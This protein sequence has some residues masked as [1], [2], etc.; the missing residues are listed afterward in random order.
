MPCVSGSYF[1]FSEYFLIFRLEAYPLNLM[2]TTYTSDGYSLRILA[3]I[4]HGQSFNIYDLWGMYTDKP[5]AY[6]PK[7]FD[8]LL[9]EKLDTIG[10]APPGTFQLS[11]ALNKY[12]MDQLQ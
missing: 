3:I 11:C 2:V 7:I 5:P 9:W 10:D 4:F 1:R 8:P 12:L 6:R